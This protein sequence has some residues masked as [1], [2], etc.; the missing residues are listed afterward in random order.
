MDTLDLPRWT[1]DLLV[2]L[3]EHEDTHAKDSTCLQTVLD[4]VPEEV[5]AQAKT[6][7][8]YL[9]TPQRIAYGF[10]QEVPER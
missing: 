8:G 5:R 9:N 10:G 6:V 4:T 2:A 7:R 3:L 1:W